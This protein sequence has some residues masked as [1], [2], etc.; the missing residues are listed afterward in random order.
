MT[1]AEH[2]RILAAAT[3]LAI[4]V[5]EAATPAEA[6]Q[7]RFPHGAPPALAAAITEGFALMRADTQ[8]FRTDTVEKLLGRKPKSFADWCARNA[9]VFR[10]ES[11]A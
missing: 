6:V 9:E 11:A 1:V 5:R 8:G 10:G 3:G 7:A 4:D 2:V